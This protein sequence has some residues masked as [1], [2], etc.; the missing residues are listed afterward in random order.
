MAVVQDW[1]DA[2]LA[3]IPEPLDGM[4]ARHVRAT[5]QEFF[6]ES[7]AWR[8]EE[9]LDA[10]KG[11][12]RFAL[13]EVPNDC[14]PVSLR[15]GYFQP[16]VGDGFRLT[17]TLEERITHTGS[18]EPG[19]IALNTND[20]EVI[21]DSDSG[22]GSL[23]VRYIVQ[24]SRAIES[25]PDIIADKWFNGIKQGAMA[26]LLAMSNQPW[27]DRVVAMDYMELFHMAI[28]KAKKEARRDRTRPRR[29]A[30][31]NSGFAW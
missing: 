3:D 2:I 8:V 26:Y 17:N 27:S 23:K 15:W 1:V 24:P 31:F 9:T 13:L 25:V 6:R 18:G 22:V 30:K 16:L 21:I 11:I 10:E 5:I 12:A 29:V 28:D 14:Y 19:V 7:E 20:V 4:V